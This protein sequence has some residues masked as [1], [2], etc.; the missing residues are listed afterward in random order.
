MVPHWPVR[1]QWPSVRHEFQFR[2]NRTRLR[3]GAGSVRIASRA[4]GREATRP[5]LSQTS[6]AAGAFSG[7]SENLNAKVLET[8]GRCR[9]RTG[10]R[11]NSPVSASIWSSAQE[12]VARRPWV[13]PRTRHDG[14]AS[15]AQRVHSGCRDPNGHAQGA[16]S[17]VGFNLG[18]K[19]LHVGR[20]SSSVQRVTD[21]FAGVF[22]VPLRR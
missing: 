4:G 5:A 10:I 16:G 2:A 19:D 1:G 15:A 18:F 11:W 20:G 13:K 9:A 8:E 12:D 17:A 3:R 14:R 21:Y 7:R 22:L 6:S